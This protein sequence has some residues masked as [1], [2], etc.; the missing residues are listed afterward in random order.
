MSGMVSKLPQNLGLE[1]TQVTVRSSIGAF[2]NTP[3]QEVHP[4]LL[5]VNAPKNN[6]QLC[7]SLNKTT[8]QGTNTQENAQ[9][10]KKAA[11]W[12]SEI[13]CEI[14]KCLLSKKRFSIN[15]DVSTSG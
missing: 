9:L 6:Q 10:A 2:V 4:K 8:L 3:S 12:Q 5:I 11:T 14:L 1:N 7:R 13:H 15:H